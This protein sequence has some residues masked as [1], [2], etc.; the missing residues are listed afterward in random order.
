METTNATNCEAPLK[1]TT[2]KLVWA[3]MT[4]G[5]DGRSELIKVVFNHEEADRAVSDNPGMFF[6]SGPVPLL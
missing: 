2:V 5:I 4:K 1:P 6:K 3:V